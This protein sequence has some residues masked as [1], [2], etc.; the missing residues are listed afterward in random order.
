MALAACARHNDN[1]VETRFIA[2]PTT[3]ASPQLQAID[4]LMWQQPNSALACL[5]PYFDTCCRGVSR[6][7]SEDTN[8]TI[9]GDVSRNVST[10]YNHHYANLLLAE[11]LYKNDYAQTNHAELQQAVSYFDSLTSTLNHHHHASWRH[12]DLEPPSPERNDNLIFLDARAH[13]INGVGYYENDSMVEACKEYLKALEVMESHFGKKELGGKKAQFM[14]LTHTR[15]IGLFSDLYLHEQA[16]YFGKTAL[17]YYQKYDASPWHLA[18]VLNEIGSHYDMMDNYDS[19]DYY[20]HRSLSLLPD[21][22]NLIHRDIATHVAYLSYKRGESSLL[23]LNQIHN[24]LTLAENKKEYLSRCLTLGEIY[25]FEQ[26]FDSASPYYSIVYEGTESVASKKLAAKRLLEINKSDDY[27]P[28]TSEYATYVA[29]FATASERQGALNSDLIELYRQYGQNKAER[30]HAQRI[31]S[32]TIRVMWIVGFLVV[33]VLLTLAFNSIVRSRNKT[34]RAQKQ[35]AEKRLETESYAHRMQQAALSG[36]L[37]KSNEALRDTSKQLEK[38]IGEKKLSEPTASEIDFTSF[39]ATP[40]CRQILETIQNN[41]FKSKM[42]CSVY[43][44]HALTKEQLQQIRCSAD[45]HIAQFT[46]RLRKQFPNL[47]DEDLNYC[48]LYLLGLSD[49]EVSAL[50]QRAY[51]TVCERNRKIKRIIR[52]QGELSVALRELV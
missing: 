6:N 20:Y 49:A 30:I 52:A 39:K 31:K 14:A 8:D 13:Y 32:I 33:L 26:L 10:T 4:S 12:G 36:K 42:D 24:L 22:N 7:V 16:I 47:T 43:K 17:E 5:L 3:I 21:T 38:A 46:I 29:Q 9:L 15:L 28:K 1:L 34:L 2:S 18:W 41:Y 44:E 40:V 37:K 50:M 35:E 45:K 27:N 48:C 19:A 11:L 23:S 51:P 25:Y